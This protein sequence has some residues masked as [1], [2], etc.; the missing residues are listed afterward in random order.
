[1]Y[2]GH[3]QTLTETSQ[4]FVPFGSGLNSKMQ[5]TPLALLLLSVIFLLFIS[6]SIHF[7]ISLLTPRLGVFQ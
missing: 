7:D 6:Y 2:E 5:N 4:D 1:M 3:E